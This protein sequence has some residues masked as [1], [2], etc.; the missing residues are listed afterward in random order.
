[1]IF[2]AIVN[3]QNSPKM[4]GSRLSS[5]ITTGRC[6]LAATSH[7]EVTGS[8]QKRQMGRRQPKQGKPPIL[9]PSK[10]VLYHVVH[11]AWQK[12]EDVEELLWRRHA[13]N[14]AVVSLREVF[15]A[16]IAQNASHGQGIE[17]MKEAEALEFDELIL[18]NQKRNEAKRAARESRESEATK[19]TKRVILD[20]IHVE[21]E[22]RNLE[23]KAAEEEVKRAIERSSG[24]VDRENLEKKI[25]EALEKPTIYDF[26]IDRAGNKYF[27]P[28]PVKYQEG[29][30]TRQKGRLYDQT[31]GTQ[32][33]MMEEAAGGE[34]RH[35]EQ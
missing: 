32:M 26:A 12:P 30:P 9:P 13:Y 21:L 35:L 18:E 28:Q 31:L 24:F 15:R 11:A 25:L 6:L 14:N 8:I 34:K 27:V 17:A 23:K 22:K 29:T 10:K 4:L 1:M 3:F 5:T 19:E 33:G 16:E 2:F 7:A 20:E